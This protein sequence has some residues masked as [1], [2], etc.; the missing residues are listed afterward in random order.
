MTFDEYSKH[1]DSTRRY[2][3]SRRE[4][5]EYVNT[6]FGGEV[7]EYLNEYKKHLREVGEHYHPPLGER[8]TNLLLEL[9]D[10][11]WYLSRIAAELDSSLSEVAQMNVDKLRA[12]YGSVRV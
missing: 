8:R 6:A 4:A 12:R 1:V 10:T 5:F 9:G 11:L 7:G 3:G 2:I